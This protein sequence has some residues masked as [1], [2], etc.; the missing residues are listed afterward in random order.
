MVNYPYP[1]NSVH[2]DLMSKAFVRK[3][4]RGKKKPVNRP[5]IERIQSYLAL[6]KKEDEN[7]PTKIK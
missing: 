7:S 6:K 1:C 3:R 4:K 2:G 5:Q